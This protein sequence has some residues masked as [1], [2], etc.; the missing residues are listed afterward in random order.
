MRRGSAIY[1]TRL[2]KRSAKNVGESFATNTL[3][4]AAPVENIS[5][6]NVSPLR[7]SSTRVL[8]AI[9][10][11]NSNSL[12]LP[13]QSKRLQML[14]LVAAPARFRTSTDSTFKPEL[15]TD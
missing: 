1:A 3:D 10:A 11:R 8:S 14:A 4:Y 13:F 12:P 5:A 15:A 9:A 6:Q 2:L 7:A